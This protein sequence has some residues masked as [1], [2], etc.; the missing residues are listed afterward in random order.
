M[1]PGS[2]ERGHHMGVLAPQ[3]EQGAHGFGSH[4]A[5]ADPFGDRGDSGGGHGVGQRGRLLQERDLA[6]KLDH[7][8]LQHGR[9]AVFD[10]QVRQVCGDELHQAGVG[11]VDPNLG[12]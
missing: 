4:L 12:P 6:W 10:D 7:A 5:L 2:H 3:A 11:L 8:R 9:V 1:L